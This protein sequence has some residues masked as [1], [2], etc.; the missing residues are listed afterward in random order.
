MNSNTLNDVKQQ[1]H[2]NPSY[3]MFEDVGGEGSRFN[4]C[5]DHQVNILQ[6]LALFSTQNTIQLI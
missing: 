6:T 3:V 1:C 5:T 4:F 2:D